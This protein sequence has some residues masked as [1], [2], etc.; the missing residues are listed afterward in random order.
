MIVEIGGG[1]ENS[2]SKISPGFDEYICRFVKYL[3]QLGIFFSQVFWSF[4][5]KYFLLN[6][7]N[8]FSKHGE[9]GDFL[10]FS[11][12]NIPAFN[13][14]NKYLLSVCYVPDTVLD[15]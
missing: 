7:G 9:V 15:A 3:F 12:E 6:L 1:R 14:F 4:Y 2:A 10:F 11:T 5:V 13:L 8:H